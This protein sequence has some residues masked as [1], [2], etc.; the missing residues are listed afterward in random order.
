M[1]E[2]PKTPEA[3]KPAERTVADIQ[4]QYTSLCNKA[5]H[6]NYQISVHSK[7]LEV[8]YA[9]LRD[10]NFEAASLQAK[11]AQK[12]AEEQLAKSAAEKAAAANLPESKPAQATTEAPKPKRTR[13]PKEVNQNVQ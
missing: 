4:G 6:L 5:G 13:K 3:P 11:Q 9:T 1:S 12:N 2:Q 7:D 8:I 10:L